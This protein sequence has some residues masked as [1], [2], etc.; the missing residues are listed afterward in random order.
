MAYN[1][2]KSAQPW[3]A[4]SATSRGSDSSAPA[5]PCP[6]P[7]R[8]RP[9]SIAFSDSTSAMSPSGEC[10]CHYHFTDCIMKC[11]NLKLKLSAGIDA[12]S[13][14]WMEYLNCGVVSFGRKRKHTHTHDSDVILRYQSEDIPTTIY[15]PVDWAEIKRSMESNA[16]NGELLVIND[17]LLGWHPSLTTH[18]WWILIVRAVV[19]CWT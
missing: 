7:A 14:G 11:G 19:K 9:H 15:R 5:S 1:T 10:R 13:C 2:N 12:Q 4:A 18:K 17:A 8:L 6:S 3:G 16:W